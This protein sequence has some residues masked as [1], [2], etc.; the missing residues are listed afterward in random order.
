MSVFESAIRIFLDFENILE[1][2]NLIY[3]VNLRNK[4]VFIFL[5]NE[6]NVIYGTSIVVDNTFSEDNRKLFQMIQKNSST[7]SNVDDDSRVQVHLIRTDA[8][9]N[10]PVPIQ[11]PDLKF[12]DADDGNMDQKNFDS[13]MMP[14]F[15]GTSSNSIII[16]PLNNTRTSSNPLNSGSS[17]NPMINLPLNDT[18]TSS[19]P[20][21][22]IRSNPM[23]IEISSYPMINLPLNINNAQIPRTKTKRRRKKT[24]LKK[25]IAKGKA[26]K[27]NLKQPKNKFFSWRKK[28]EHY[29]CHLCDFEGMNIR[30][31][32]YHVK[33][34]HNISKLDVEN[35]AR[36]SLHQCLLCNEEVLN[37]DQHYKPKHN[38]TLEDYF[39]N[40][41]AK[42]WTNQCKLANN[43]DL[44]EPAK[45]AEGKIYNTD[46]ATK[47]HFLS[48][49]KKYEYYHCQLC[50]NKDFKFENYEGFLNHMKNEHDIINS[51]DDKFADIFARMEEH[52]CLLCGDQVSNLSKLSKLALHFNDKHQISLEHYFKS[53]I[54]SSDDSIIT[55][56]MNEIHDLDSWKDKCLF[57]CMI[58]GY[59]T[60]TNP[61]FALHLKDHWINPSDYIKAYGSSLTYIVS[62]YCK[63]CGVKV[64]H[65]NEDLTEHFQNVH[66]TSLKLYYQNHILI[67]LGQNNFQPMDIS[68]MAKTQI[69]GED[70]MSEND[71]RDFHNWMN[72]CKFQCKICQ[73]E[74]NSIKALSAHLADHSKTLGNYINEYG[75]S[76]MTNVELHQCKV[77]SKKICHE[78][79]LLSLHVRSIHKMTLIKYYKIHIGNWYMFKYGLSEDESR[80]FLKWSN[81]MRKD[82]IHKCKLCK[83]E[84]KHVSANLCEH[85][86]QEHSMTLAYYYQHHVISGKS[87]TYESPCSSLTSS[88]ENQESPCNPVQSNDIPRPPGISSRVN[89]LTELKN[90]CNSYVTDS[91]SLSNSLTSSCNNKLNIPLPRNPLPPN[92]K[93]FLNQRPEHKNSPNSTVTVSKSP[94]TSISLQDSESPCISSLLDQGQKSDSPCISTLDRNM[95]VTM[96]EPGD[97]QSN[98]KTSSHRG[99]DSTSTCISTLKPDEQ[100]SEVPC[101]TSQKVKDSESSCIST[102]LPDD[103]STSWMNRND[104]KCGICQDFKTKSKRDFLLHI[105]IKHDLA[106]YDDYKL[107]QGDPKNQSIIFICRI[108]NF[109]MDHDEYDVKYHLDEDHRGMSI[110]DYQS[111]FNIKILPKIE[112][113]KLMFDWDQCEYSCPICEKMTKTK[114]VAMNHLKVDH[115]KQRRGQLKQSKNLIL[116]HKCKMCSKYILFEKSL[117]RSH[118]KY[119]HLMYLTDYEKLFKSELKATF[120]R[121]FKNRLR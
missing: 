28:F 106:S 8:P 54:A 104:Y 36:I 58:C 66:K 79:H 105:N 78:E 87:N 112:D 71:R 119:H 39:K 95:S 27:I 62:H 99:K 52:C 113:E 80:K 20:V 48:W 32:S 64:L 86:N 84:I 16:E 2:R 24:L 53:H 19:N 44:S 30:G 100:N 76:I 90:K 45:N 109:D 94:I 11:L 117:M 15:D 89:Q 56:S 65:Q 81:L 75:S 18:G 47:A 59:S 34:I 13:S 23:N 92:N 107:K 68:T 22:S 49:K 42:D 70:T 72:S 41:I 97:E 7:T 38:M 118:L 60:K 46:A 35:Y 31:F 85:F 3:N 4:G 108:C 5:G 93:I 96:T 1:I 55:P 103:Q 120:A 121:L 115:P 50:E 114:K 67:D 102:L 29:S 116:R 12:E 9:N 77:C 21:S 61:D 73:H 14:D 63:F 17:S 26:S 51:D 110:Q 57:S 40:H 88:S 69:P 82:A 74:A 10:I 25:T 43:V 101:T 6:H 91:K 37:L 83:A 98:K 33:K 111:K